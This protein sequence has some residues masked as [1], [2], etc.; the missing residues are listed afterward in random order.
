[1][2]MR[3]GLDGRPSLF[4]VEGICVLFACTPWPY[5]GCRNMFVVAISA[6]SWPLVSSK[7]HSKG[8]PLVT[9]LQELD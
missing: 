4:V 5:D 2:D 8:L 9:R 7:L 1:M 6:T 3:K